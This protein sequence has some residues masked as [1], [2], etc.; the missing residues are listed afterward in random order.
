MGV[1]GELCSWPRG[2]REGSTLAVP[3]RQRGHRPGHDWEGVVAVVVMI[4]MVMMTM[5]MTSVMVII[6]LCHSLISPCNQ[7]H[8]H[9]VCAAGCAAQRGTAHT[10]RKHRYIQMYSSLCIRRYSFLSIPWEV[11][12]YRRYTRAPW[13][14]EQTCWFSSSFFL[15]AMLVSTSML[16]GGRC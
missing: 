4:S 3:S 11:I 1:S 8:S 2:K 9:N 12:I 10:P 15:L 13:R 16:M 6:V 5:M 7:A 14:D